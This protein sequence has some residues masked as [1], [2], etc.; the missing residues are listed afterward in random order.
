MAGRLHIGIIGNRNDAQVVRIGEAVEKLGAKAV[1]VDLTDIPAYVDFHWQGNSLSYGG[2]DLLSLDAVFARTVHFPMP[3]S[4]LGMGREE[5]KQRTFPVRESGSLMNSVVDELSKAIPFINPP[6]PCRYHRIKPSMYRTLKQAGVP[7]PEFAV[8]CSLAGAAYFVDKHNE[9]VVLKPLM[10]GEVIEADLTFLKEHHEEVDRRPLL[11]QRRIRGRSLRVYVIEDEVVA[12]AEIVHGD[13]VDW[14]NDV[15]EICP[16]ELDG[17]AKKAAV[18][19]VRALGLVF[20]SLDIEEESAEV[21]I[22]WVIDVNPGPMFT[23]FEIKSGLDVAGHLAET[24]VRVARGSH[25]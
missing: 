11:L 10:G 15:Q 17:E 19:A 12:A 5:A 21:K 9:E 23:G 22:P 24:L 13:V 8:G 6:G 2:V 3:T 20:A 4:V 7:V 18:N 16:V 1:L 25:H 14:R